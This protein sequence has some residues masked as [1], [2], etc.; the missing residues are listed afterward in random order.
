M[1][2]FIVSVASWMFGENKKQLAKEAER[3]KELE[4]EGFVY[5]TGYSSENETSGNLIAANLRAAVLAVTSRIGVNQFE[6]GGDPTIIGS[7]ITGGR[8]P[9]DVR[10][11]G[12]NSIII[13]VVIIGILLWSIFFRKKQRK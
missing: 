9:G 12:T 2:E 5:K 3:Q 13:I 4:A 1:F 10:T 7:V 11:T 8:P 6:T